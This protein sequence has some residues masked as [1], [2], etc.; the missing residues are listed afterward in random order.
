[1]NQVINI[2]ITGLNN[3]GQGFW[4]YAAGMFIQASVL[5][6]LLLILD[7]MLR[8][9][10]RAVFRY[11]LWM[12]LFVKLVLPASFTGWGISFQENFR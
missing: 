5:I 10:V 4:D 1:M 8:K 9:R 2:F 12:L 3:L 6:A 7:F 11:C